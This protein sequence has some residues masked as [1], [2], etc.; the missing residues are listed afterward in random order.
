MDMERTDTPFTGGV[1][2]Y[3]LVVVYL[4]P[5]VQDSELR[6]SH[7]VIVSALIGPLYGRDELGGKYATIYLTTVD[8]VTYSNLI[9]NVRTGTHKDTVTTSSPGGCCVTINS[10]V[11]FTMVY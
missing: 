5:S 8:V 9:L 6:N 4:P 7:E 3:I 10:Y 1:F 2:I 11:K